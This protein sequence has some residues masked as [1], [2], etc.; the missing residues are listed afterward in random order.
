M[1][2]SGG[3]AYAHRLRRRT[4]PRVTHLPRHSAWLRHFSRLGAA[5]RGQGLRPDTPQSSRGRG[6]AA[7]HSRGV[8]PR[9][10]AHSKPLK[11]AVRL[12]AR[13]FFVL[14]EERVA[15]PLRENPGA[16]RATRRYRR[17]ALR[18]E[19]PHPLLP[20]DPSASQR[21]ARQGVARRVDLITQRSASDNLQVTQIAASTSETPAPQP[22]AQA[23]TSSFRPRHRDS[24]SIA[25]GQ[26]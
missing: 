22:V 13:I 26:G 9:E 14:W 25:Q 8:L 19:C 20:D 10:A 16:L 12:F 2:H 15:E 24:W 1:S 3:C 23:R 6:A 17:G 11:A 5:P 18:S 7:D 21:H 4:S